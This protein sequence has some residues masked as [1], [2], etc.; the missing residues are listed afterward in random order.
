MRI[1]ARFAFIEVFAVSVTFG[2]QSALTVP[3]AAPTT[4]TV[5]YAGPGVIRPELAPL[6]L[7]DPATGHCK[8][9]NGSLV[10]SAVID[11]YGAPHEI[12]FLKPTGDDLD[13]IAIRLLEKE[14]FKPGTRDGIP[15]AT[16]VA[17]ELNMKG[18]MEKSKDQAGQTVYALALRSLPT[19]KIDLQQ[20]PYEGATLEI[21]GA[22]SPPSSG[23]DANLSKVGGNISAPKPIK[24]P[25]ANYSDEARRAKIMGVCVVSL[26]V[27][28]NGMPQHPKI[29]RSLEESL[30]EEAIRAIERW[31]FK[32]AMKNGST[33]VPVAITV[34]MDFHLY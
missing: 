5:Y 13:K 15:A 6:T 11:A 23:G 16:I 2:Q 20:P 32:P 12:Y 19:E 25:S 18:C 1:G 34:E 14:R 33:P 3:S 17:I 4:Q 29:I 22:S 26:I 21:N 24:S 9:F 8:H 30:D 7:S 31:R 27:D 28:A 10:L